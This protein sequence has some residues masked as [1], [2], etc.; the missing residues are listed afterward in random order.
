MPQK[1]NPVSQSDRANSHLN[2]VSWLACKSFFWASASSWQASPSSPSCPWL[3]AEGQ[4]QLAHWSTPNTHT[5]CCS[6]VF[7]FFVVVFLLL[8]FFNPQLW[9]DFDKSIPLKNL[10]FNSSAV[11]TDICSYPEVF[12][13]K[14]P[15]VRGEHLH[16]LRDT[17]WPKGLRDYSRTLV[18]SASSS[19]LFFF[20]FH[21]LPPCSLLLCP[22]SCSVFCI[23]PLTTLPYFYL[24]SSSSLL[25]FPTLPTIHWSISFVSFSPDNF[26]I[27]SHLSNPV[28][29]CARVSVIE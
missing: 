25:S 13:C 19:F 17:H 7:L 12:I 6:C 16:Q 27:Q 11:F 3:L 20:P 14:F 23:F 21:L 4:Q 26:I 2:P 5:D 15:V 29:E 24:H 18:P 9:C 8:L 1:H 22:L 28:E 10:T